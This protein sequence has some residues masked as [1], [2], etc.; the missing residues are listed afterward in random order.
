MLKLL[1][2]VGTNTGAVA[3]PFHILLTLLVIKGQGKL[4]EEGGKPHYVHIRIFLAPA[5]QL[6][7]YICLC[8][9]LAYI[10]GH[11]MFGP[12]PV[13]RQVIIHM[14]RIP[15]Q[16]SQEADRILVI[17]DTLDNH[18]SGCFIVK[19]VFYRDHLA[20]CPVYDLPPALWL[21]Y[22]VDLQLLCV[23]SLHQFNGK[24]P[25]GSRDAIRDQIFLLYFLRVVLRPFVIFAG[26]IIGCVN[27]CT[28]F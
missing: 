23:E 9:R 24:R 7:F 4:M 6:L 21:I 11:L 1:Q 28:S 17:W 22:R 2:Y 5:S 16:K 27:F 13:I 12:L 3:E 26:C 15:D 14:N 18:F 10:K 25:A 19:P 8:L 20:G